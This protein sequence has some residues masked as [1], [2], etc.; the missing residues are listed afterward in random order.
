MVLIGAALIGFLIGLIF[1]YWKQLS[2]IYQNRDT[3]GQ[4]EKVAEG[5]QALKDLWEKI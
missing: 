5:G 3:I 4:V 2:A 1:C